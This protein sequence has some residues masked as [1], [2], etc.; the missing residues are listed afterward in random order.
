M[1]DDGLIMTE[2]QQMILQLSILYQSLSINITKSAT[3]PDVNGNGINDTN[4]II[5]YSIVINNNGNLT[6]SNLS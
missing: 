1:C 4:D 6:L 2:I 5:V 3:V